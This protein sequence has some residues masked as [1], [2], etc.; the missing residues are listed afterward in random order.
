MRRIA[1]W[2]A[3]LPFVLM[4]LILPGTMLVRD[5]LGR[6]T[7][8]LCSGAG[9]MQMRLTADGSLVADTPTAPVDHACDWAPHGRALAPGATLDPP[10]ALAGLSRAWLAPAPAVPQPRA[11]PLPP[12]ARGPPRPV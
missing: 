3:V 11:R 9:P 1:L 5:A 10:Q 6:V 8:V 7:V 4:S 12:V 2:L